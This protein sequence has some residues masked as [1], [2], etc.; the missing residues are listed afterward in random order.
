MENRLRVR[1]V[2]CSRSTKLNQGHKSSIPR[3]VCSEECP[4]AYRE[5]V[6][7]GKPVCCFECIPCPQGEITNQETDECM[8]CPDDHW[9][10]DN[11]DQCIPKLIEFLSFDEPLGLT[12]SFTAAFLAFIAACILGIF[13]KYGTTPIVKA[14][15]LR[16][17]YLLL[18]FLILCFLCSFIFIGHP[19]NLSC[20]LRQ[21]VFG[22]VFSISIA[23]VLAKTILAVLAFKA[24][25]PNS[26]ARKW[27][28]GKTPSFIVSLCSLIQVLICALWLVNAPPFPEPD[29]ISDNGKII[30]ECNEGTHFFYSML[31]YMGL[32]A[33]VSFIVA[34]LS[35]NLPG[36]FNE[37]K[38]IT[39]SMLVFVSVWISFIP[40]YLSTQGKFMVAV[41]V[42]AIQCSS[43][44]L[45]GCIFFP[46]CYII[47]FTPEMNNR[48]NIIGRTHF[49]TIRKHEDH[50]IRRS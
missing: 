11:H 47:L 15:N 41:E 9:P 4:P 6:I 21:T 37:A 5:A 14:N 16:L 29:L 49:G 26:P 30:L 28:G 20:M 8:K 31:G 18:F 39:F 33:T 17:S 34:F 45:L 2:Q 38:L 13:L 19:S 36:T 42:F 23:I 1:R 7:R 44:G 10:N 48:H 25:L 50:K 27:L 24:K 22:I 32:L 46:K 12:L 35:R 3:S 43:A 40:A